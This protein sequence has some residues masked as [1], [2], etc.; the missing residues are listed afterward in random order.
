MLFFRKKAVKLPQRLGSVP[1]AHWPPGG[2]L[3]PQTPVVTPAKQQIFCFCFL[4]ACAYF[5]L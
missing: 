2:G 4:R 3:R 1:K 5:S